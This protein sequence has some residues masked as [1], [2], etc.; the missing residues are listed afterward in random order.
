MEEKLCLPSG[1]LDHESLKFPL[2]ITERG[3][4]A[5]HVHIC[6]L[7]QLFGGIGSGNGSDGWCH[8]LLVLVTW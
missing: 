3:S 2:E 1:T 6:K 8:V 7:V 4:H 5:R